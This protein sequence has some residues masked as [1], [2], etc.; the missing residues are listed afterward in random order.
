[1]TDLGAPEDHVDAILR[2]SGRRLRTALAPVPVTD[3]RRPGSRRR[4]WVIAIATV[5]VLIVG[6]V[7]IGTNRN[8]QS[9]GNDPSRLH[10]LLTD[11]PAG[12]VPVQMSEPGDQ[13]QTGPPGV[14]AMINVYATDASPLGPIVSVAGSLGLRDQDI[15][16]AAAGTNFHETTI[17][18]RRAANADGESGRR[19]LYVEVDGHWVVLTSRN[20]DDATLTKMAQAV[21]R[22]ADGSAAIP[23]A[24]LVDGLTLV[25]PADAPLSELGLGSNFAGISYG[26]P[27]GRSIGLQVYA[28]KPSARANLGLSMSLTPTK[29]AGVDGFL[30]HYTIEGFVHP[31]DVR[32]A[33]WVRDGLQFRITGFDVTDVEVLAAAQSVERASDATWDELLQKTGAGEV[34]TGTTPAGTTPAGTV[35]AEPAPPGTDPPF[36]GDVRDVVVDVSVANPSSNEQIWSGTLPTGEAWSVDINWVFDYVAMQP[37]IDGVPQGSSYGPLARSPGEEIGCC[38]PLNVI[39]ADPTAVAVRV[40][41]NHGDR[42][43][44]PLHDLP[45]TDGLRIAAIALAGGGGPQ[46]AELIDAAGNVLQT[47]PGGS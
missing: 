21:V 43:S 16:P 29:V 26:D 24:D 15:V 36:T 10:W 14:T 33:S 47:M 13:S 3:F 11:L 28:P 41:T 7:A 35:P 6:L 39:T 34:P 1:M 8:D 37:R 17:A 32:V 5:V 38:A 42:F 18:G 19:L 2:S 45:G 44:I 31:T 27:D 25:L 40:T 4:G 9:L 12:L 46:R 20:I 23:S 22:S 30:G